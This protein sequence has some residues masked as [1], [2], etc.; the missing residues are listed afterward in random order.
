MQVKTVFESKQNIFNIK[1]VI[2]EKKKEKNISEYS[3]ESELETDVKRT[4]LLDLPDLCL[5]KILRNLDLEQLAIV[6]SVSG[7]LKGN[8]IHV[9]KMNFR[10]RDLETKQFSDTNID[11]FEVILQEFGPYFAS[12]KIEYNKSQTFVDALL[13]Y[14]GA[15]LERLSVELG[16]CGQRKLSINRP[17]A[18]VQHLTY[19][20]VGHNWHSSWCTGINQWFP[21]LQSLHISICQSEARIGD[22]L[23]F[24]IPKLSKLHIRC[25][26]FYYSHIRPN[27]LP[28]LKSNPQLETVFFNNMESS[29]IF[30]ENILYE[31]ENC[32][33][34]TLFLR[35]EVSLAIK[36]VMK[37]KHLEY[38]NISAETF[39]DF[40]KINLPRLKFLFLNVKSE[41]YNMKRIMD[42][43]AR[44][45]NLEV[46]GIEVDGDAQ[47]KSLMTLEK[48]HKLNVSARRYLDIDRLTLPNIE[49]L[50]I[51]LLPDDNK[52]I[53]NFIKKC[54][55]LTRLD[56]N[57][58]SKRV[59]A[60]DIDLLMETI[61]KLDNLNDI[62]C[63]GTSDLRLKGLIT[64]IP[65]ARNGGINLLK[66]ARES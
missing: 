47:L 28:L 64:S 22:L 58:A 52:S 20:I 34:S 25:N 40:E 57:F 23:T 3:L 55:H 14:S 42:F 56:I 5:D 24:N 41:F 8:A 26:G 43:I 2:F 17:F 48:L 31:W 46:L 59:N 19:S 21:E 11:L 62:S 32:R 18:N 35:E 61:E 63:R 39:L 15:S 13:E 6:A 50:G 66:R 54:P 29:C 27:M 4:T 44:C 51:T 12:A 16:E 9:F 36:N 60:K 37:L 7:C 38:L 30:G 53:I 33:I 65:K 45:N 10:H 49:K 1:I